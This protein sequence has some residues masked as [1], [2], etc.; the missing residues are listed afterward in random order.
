MPARLVLVVA[1]LLG[2]AA[3]AAEIGVIGRKLVIVDKVAAAGLA[4]VVYVSKDRAAG[5]TKGS[6][7]DQAGIEATFVVGYAAAAGRIHMPSGAFAAA[8]GWQVSGP[9]VAKFVNRDAPGGGTVAKVGVIKQGRLLKVVGKG[10]GDGPVIDILTAGAPPGDVHTAFTVDNAGEINSHCSTFAGC[11]YKLIAGGTGAKLVCRNSTADPTCAALAPG[12]TTTT[13]TSSTTTTSTFV[14]G[15]CGNGVVDQASEACDLP[16]PGVCDDFPPPV[17]ITCGPPA[18]SQPCQCCAATACILSTFGDIPCCDGDCQD[19]TGVGT[20]R[21]G[22]CI[23]PTCQSDADCNGY[24]CVGGA[25]CGGGGSLC[26]VVDCCPGTGTTCSPVPWLGAP[27]CCR[28][29]GGSCG[30]FSECCSGSCSA[31]LCD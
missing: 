21:G 30:A 4:K 26:G 5:I 16:D 23:P 22:V 3:P 9:T 20:V 6:G 24:Q 15:V 31:G 10:L 12:T 17:P 7:T 13:S 28:P 18:S 27:V 2:P 14:A 25:C 1:L 11:V 19:T 8:E 29:A